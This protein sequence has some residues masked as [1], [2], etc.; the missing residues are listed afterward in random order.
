MKE[1]QKDFHGL[2]WK[3]YGVPIAALIV[4][5][6]WTAKDLVGKD[7]ITKYVAP[8]TPFSFLMIGLV[9]AIA[10]AYL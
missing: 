9:I 1:M 6:G 2:I 4:V 7:D 8:T 3:S 10:R 5:G